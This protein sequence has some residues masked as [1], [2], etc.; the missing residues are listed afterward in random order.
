[1]LSLFAS[2]SHLDQLASKKNL[3]I[4]KVTGIFAFL[5][6]RVFHSI[7]RSSCHFTAFSHFRVSVSSGLVC[8]HFRPT[9]SGPCSRIAFSTLTFLGIPPSHTLFS[10]FIAYYFVFFSVFFQCADPVRYFFTSRAYVHL[11]EPYCRCSTLTSCSTHH[12]Y[13][14]D[15]LSTYS[16]LFERVHSLTTVTFFAYRLIV[17]ILTWELG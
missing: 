16:R 8:L 1:M 13:L 4:F 12:E 14:L 5:R 7:S 2:C 3:R 6:T 17:H 10:S 11:R 15:S 9:S